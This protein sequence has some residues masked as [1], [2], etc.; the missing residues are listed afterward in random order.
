MVTITSFSVREG[1]DGKPA[2]FIEV[3]GEVELVQ[4]MT[5]G[6]HYFQAKRASLFAALPESIVK[7]MVGRQMPGS[8]VRVPAEPYDFVTS[9]GET[10]TLAH[11]YDY[12]PDE[13]SAIAGQVN[14]ADSV[15]V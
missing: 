3:T 13:N 10:I 5:T 8:I 2:I 4:S 12:Q 14:A 11:R 15:L 9:G 1:K 7:T 6:R